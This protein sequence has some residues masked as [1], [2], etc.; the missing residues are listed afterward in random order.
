L[1][2]PSKDCRTGICF[3]CRQHETTLNSVRQ[4]ER[5]RKASALLQ[6]KRDTEAIKADVESKNASR[7]RKLKLREDAQ[8]REAEALLRAGKNPYEVGWKS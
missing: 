4:A 2:Y 7:Q 3:L 5:G 6:L 1:I 8:A